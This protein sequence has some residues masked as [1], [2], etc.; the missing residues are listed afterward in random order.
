MILYQTDLSIYSTKVR[1]ALALKGVQ[2]EMRDPPDGY[3]SAA[4]RALV[5][6]ATI[7]A[8][9]DGAM[10]LSESDAIIEY[11]DET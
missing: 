1:L 2:V 7:P 5:P 11:F 9:V 10:V 4:Y 3:R 8:L 6:P